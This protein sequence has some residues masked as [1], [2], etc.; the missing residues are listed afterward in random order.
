MFQL[1]LLNKKVVMDCAI[2]YILMITEHNGDVSPENSTFKIHYYRNSKSD[3][4]VRVFLM[5]FRL[6]MLS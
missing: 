3:R 2:I 4:N 5:T 1:S 6:K